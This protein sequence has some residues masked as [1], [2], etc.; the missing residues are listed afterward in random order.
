MNFATEPDQYRHTVDPDDQRLRPSGAIKRD[1]LLLALANDEL[2]SSSLLRAHALARVLEAE[3]HILRVLPAPMHANT[4]FPQWNMLDAMRAIEHT[5]H[6]GRST[7][8]WLE[9]VLAEDAAR[10]E[11]FV[12]AHGDYI[13]QVATRAAELAPKLIVMPAREER[14]GALVTSLVRATG[15]P[16]LVA[17]DATHGESIVA[18]TDLESVGYPVLRKAA[19]LGRSLD[20]PLVAVHNLNPLAVVIGLELAW[21]MTVLP[22]DPLSDARG[23]RLAE[24]SSKLPGDAQAVV[25]QEVNPVDAIL[26]EARERDADLVVVGTRQRGWFDRLICGSVAAQVVNR[27]QR[28]VLVTPLSG[29]GARTVAPLARA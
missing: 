15:T 9:S 21:P 4:I 18:A 11:T 17:R 5:L 22:G 3:L 1:T 19:E 13:E 28:S 25:R 14:V 26:G 23:A 6:A 16:V 27:A 24:L 2:P 12:I 10:V 20:A 7:R 8:V 29:A